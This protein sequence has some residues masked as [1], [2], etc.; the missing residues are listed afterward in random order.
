M[1]L[2]VSRRYASQSHETMGCCQ[3]IVL[4]ETQ[5]TLI[6]QWSGLCVEVPTGSVPY[7]HLVYDGLL[8]RFLPHYITTVKPMKVFVLSKLWLFGEPENSK[9][10]V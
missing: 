7:K 2:L 4:V 10:V 1:I 6:C 5:I 9:S 3:Y 8:D